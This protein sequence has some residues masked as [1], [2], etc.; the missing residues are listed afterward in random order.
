MALEDSASEGTFL[1]SEGPESGSGTG[2]YENWFGGSPGSAGNSGARDNVVYDGFSGD[3]WY[4]WNNAYGYIAEWEGD[5]VL[6]TSGTNILSG[7]DGL[8][9]LYGTDAVTDIFVFEAASAYNGDDIIVN[10]T[11][12]DGD[13]IDISDLL[14]GYTAGASD[15]ND[16]VRST[17]SGGNSLIQV[18]ANGPAGGGG[19][20]TIGQING[21]N[22]LDADAL[23]HNASII[24]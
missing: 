4:V 9:A 15:I 5:A 17:N 11:A 12:A 14:T 16:F 2:G 24:A 1:W 10:F 13:A 8:D 22:D 21:V 7:G 6:G 20:V 18:D 23:L 3:V 19:F